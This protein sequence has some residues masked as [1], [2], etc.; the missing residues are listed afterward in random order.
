VE[1]LDT[2]LRQKQ[3]L[4]ALTDKYANVQQAMETVRSCAIVPSTVHSLMLS[5]THTAVAA[6]NQDHRDSYRIIV[7][8]ANCTLHT[9]L[10]VFLA[11]TEPVWLQL[12]AIKAQHRGEALWTALQ[13]APPA[14]TA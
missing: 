12:E 9:L 4:Q 8:Q 10:S 11:D 7:R 5:L 1:D 6:S 3:R 13:L 14:R 2:R